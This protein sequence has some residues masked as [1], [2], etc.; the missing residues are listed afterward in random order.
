M[1]FADAQA[2]QT[3]ERGVQFFVAACVYYLQR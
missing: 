2:G 3:C 1:A